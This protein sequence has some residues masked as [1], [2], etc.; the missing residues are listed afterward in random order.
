MLDIM[1]LIIGRKFT[2]FLRDGQEADYEK[3]KKMPRGR[4]FVP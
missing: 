1:L 2:F 4:V 3:K